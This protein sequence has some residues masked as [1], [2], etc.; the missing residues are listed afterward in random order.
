MTL[1]ENTFNVRNVNSARSTLILARSG[2]TQRAWEDFVK[3]GLDAIADNPAV[4]T[5]KGRLLKD[6]A[7]KASGEAKAQL[8]L[9][10]ANAYA[11]AAAL[12]PDSYPLIN[13]AT[14]SLFAA[15]PDQMARFSQEVLTLLETGTGPGETPYW[16][17]ATK[18]EGLLLLGRRTEAET[19]L[20]DAARARVAS[21]GGP[22]HYAPPVPGD[23][24]VSKRAT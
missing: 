24:D 20:R 7:R 9:Q 3:A 22:C 5:L 21:L 4:L 8:Y 2:A 18:A 15:Q 16:H 23:I 6:Q 11:D 10:S 17:D 13:A 12:R 19:A 14:M 1:A